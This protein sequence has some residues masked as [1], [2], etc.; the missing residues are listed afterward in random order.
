MRNKIHYILFFSG[1]LLSL[2]AVFSVKDYLLAQTVSTLPGSSSSDLSS[3]TTASGGQST[4]TVVGPPACGSANGGLYVS[5]PGENLCKSPNV[6]KGGVSMNGSSWNWKCQN[7]A[8]AYASCS[9]K[10]KIETQS[11]TT[12]TSTMPTATNPAPTSPTGTISNT[13][14]SSPN[15]SSS[16][17]SATSGIK[18]AGK[19]TSPRNGSIIIDKSLLFSAT[20]INAT[21]VEFSV[22]REGA[23]NSLYLGNS[24]KT[25]EGVWQLTKSGS[26]FL[27]NGAYKVIATISNQE[28]SISSDP[29]GF[30]INVP[31]DNSLDNNTNNQVQAD[32]KNINENGDGVKSE[33]QLVAA[34]DSDGDGLTDQEEI[35]IG[36]D[37]KNPDTDGDG[38]LDGDEIKNGFNPLKAADGKGSKSDKIMFQSPKEKGDTNPAYKVESVTSLP[39]ENSDSQDQKIKLNG[40]GLPNSFVTIYIYSNDPVIVTVKTNANGDWEYVLDKNLEDGDHE[41]YVAVTDNTGK[42]TAK[43]EPLFFVKTAQAVEM[44]NSDQTAGKVIPQNQSP[45]ERSQNNFVVF[46]MMIIVFCIGVAA[47]VV[48]V[49]LRKRAIY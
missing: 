32:D 5:A 49:I 23:S 16:P 40:K 38:Y 19:I 12:T 33:E 10:V 43:S 22:T 34:V 35:R 11:Q 21:K 3:N 48:A 45:V 26:D 47:M 1:F 2:L 39:I 46:A 36:T 30:Q 25:A 44:V 4:L 8:G 18:P 28:G 37:P 17:S 13:T 7:S 27:P 15:Q 41:A 31:F 14:S 9:A 24:N 29:I 20:T 42:I 6:L